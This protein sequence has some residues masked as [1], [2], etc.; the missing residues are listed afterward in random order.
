LAPVKADGFFSGIAPEEAD[1]GGVFGERF[2]G[3]EEGLAYACA[4]VGGDDAHAAELPGGLGG[5]VLA[6]RIDRFPIDAR[7]GG[8][9]D[10]H[11]CMIECAGVDGFGGLVSRELGDFA[12]AIGAEDLPAHLEYFREQGLADG[13]GHRESK[14]RERG[15]CKRRAGYR[16]GGSA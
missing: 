15:K 14:M 9:G 7:E 6:K 13:D 2:E 8:A 1:G 3:G 16:R 12:R 5:G 11:A 4:L 10:I